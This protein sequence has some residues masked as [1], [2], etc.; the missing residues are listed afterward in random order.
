MTPRIQPHPRTAKEREIDVFARWFGV[1]LRDL[2]DNHDMRLKQHSHK[3]R[4][5][6][7]E[8]QITLVTHIR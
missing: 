6:S 8:S 3:R 7:K 2:R 5:Y 4:A 1:V